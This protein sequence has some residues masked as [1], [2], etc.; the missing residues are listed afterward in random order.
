MGGL[1]E[2]HEALES[3]VVAAIEAT[4]M[5]PQRLKEL[6]VRLGMAV[7]AIE[8]PKDLD[9]AGMEEVINSFVCR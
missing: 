3:Q 1:K 2:V 4:H 7:E 5:H 6:R 9:A 8:E